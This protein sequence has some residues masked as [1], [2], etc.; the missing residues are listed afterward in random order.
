MK[1]KHRRSY[2][3][4]VKGKRGGVKAD[5]QEEM[6]EKEDGDKQSPTKSWSIRTC[7]G[8]TSRPDCTKSHHQYKF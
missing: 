1:E 4:M 8:V 5:N 3:G 2:K 7:G 6:E